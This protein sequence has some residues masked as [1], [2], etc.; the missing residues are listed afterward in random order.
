MPAKGDGFVA[1]AIMARRRA[2]EKALEAE[3]T[4]KAVADSEWIG[5]IKK[6]L[7]GLRFHVTFTREFEG[8]Y[9]TKL[10]TKGHDD[11][12]NLLVWWSSGEWLEQGHTYELDGTVKA[13]DRDSYNG[14]AKVTEITRV[15]GS[16]STT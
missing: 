13:H 5:E 9:G 10:L 3:R 7:R 1:Y 6:R 15:T 12:G 4:A 11:D 14:D 8:N 2:V 16:R